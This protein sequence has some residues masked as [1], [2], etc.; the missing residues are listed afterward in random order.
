VLFLFAQ[1]AA[2]Q[3]VYID[4]SIKPKTIQSIRAKRPKPI[5]KEWS[6][7]A[8]IATDGWGFLYEKGWVKNA[9]GR[10]AEKFYDTRVVFAALVEHKHSKEVKLQNRNGTPSAA[11][12]PYKYGK[13]NNF[14]ALKLG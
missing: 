9:Q 6:I 13:I 11:P 10:N 14:Y 7:G 5:T 12:R 4:T 1:D 8:K 2:G 3:V